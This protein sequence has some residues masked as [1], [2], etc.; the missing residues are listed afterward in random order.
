[1]ILAKTSKDILIGGISSVP[2]RNTGDYT[3]D[4]KVVVFSIT[5]RKVYNRMNDRDNLY[6][7]RGYGPLVGC[8][9]F[10]INGDTIQG[11]FY[12][13]DPFRIPKVNGN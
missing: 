11:Y 13:D 5:R 12:E 3:L 8:N 6:F 4:P 1:M 7:N 9:G 2:W 10:R